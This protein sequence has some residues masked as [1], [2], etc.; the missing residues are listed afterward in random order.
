VCGARN[1]ELAGVSSTRVHFRELTEREIR[2][3]VGTGEPSD[4]AG[5]YAIQ[6]KGGIFVDRI[7]GSPSN[8]VGFPLEVFYGLLVEAGLGLPDQ[9]F[10]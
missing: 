1:V 3:Y 2:W 9:Q 10:R 4:K 5:A 8:V 7:V 6:G